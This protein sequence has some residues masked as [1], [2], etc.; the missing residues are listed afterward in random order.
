[1]PEHDPPARNAVPA[2]WPV[3]PGE[4]IPELDV[5]R[6]LALFGVLLAYALWSLGSPPAETYSQAN[7]LLDSALTAL[8]D[9]K[10]YTLLAFLFGLG[11]ALQMTRARRR[12][13]SIVPVYCRRLAALLLIGL[14]HALLLR[15]GDILVPY[16]VTGLLLLLFR[17][18][19]HK[20]LAAG[21][22]VGLV[23]PYL[24]RGVWELSGIPFPQRPET[25]GMGYFASNYAWVRYWYE[26]AVTSWPASLPMFLCGLFIGRRRFF[27]NIS[28]HRRGLRRVLAVGLCVGAI[29]YVSR[30]LL[31]TAGPASTHAF[32]RRL[33]SGLLWSAHAWGLA[34]FY[35]SSL[36]LLLQRYRWQR[37]LAPLG[38]VGRMALTNYLLQ[39][40][41]INPVC[42]AF[43][44]FDKVTPSLGLLLA[45]S[46]WLVQVPASV[47]WL[48]RF[49]FGP[50]EWLWRSLT[51]GS[52]QPMRT[53]HNR[54]RPSTLWYGCRDALRPREGEHRTECR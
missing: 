25:E 24:A 11:F 3:G 9:S 17:N 43:D 52:P 28:A 2:L 7:R 16:A 41:I 4:R 21:A 40:V 20:T 1:M 49:R 19:S 45:L 14:A 6:G 26:T 23:L 34:A 50:V 22:I 13:A 39:S 12:G 46:V 48:K 35:A 47:W 18:A 53:P 27:E 30:S 33:T 42:I 32:G 36:L 54:R 37:W 31:L 10:A 15:N 51:Y 8:V 5:L 44:L 38:Y 29:A